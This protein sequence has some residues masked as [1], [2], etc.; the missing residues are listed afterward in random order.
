MTSYFSNRVGISDDE[1]IVSYMSSITWSYFFLSSSNLFFSGSWKIF[2]TFFIHSEMGP[3]SNSLSSNVI[4]TLFFFIQSL[5]RIMSLK[6]GLTHMIIFYW[7]SNVL[8]WLFIYFLRITFSFV[9]VLVSILYLIEMIF[10]SFFWIHVLD[11]TVI[12]VS[13]SISFSFVIIFS[14]SF[15]I[16]TERVIRFSSLDSF[17]FL[18]LSRFLIRRRLREWSSSIWSCKIV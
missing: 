11:I 16:V 7:P 10:S 8:S 3:M 2:S 14:F 6:I 18:R 9:T 5:F 4:R 13:K 1:R 15:Y 12:L 17:S